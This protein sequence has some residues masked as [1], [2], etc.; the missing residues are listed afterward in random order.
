MTEAI[1]SKA[2]L[3]RLSDSDLT[4]LVGP[5][6]V[7]HLKNKTRG[8]SNGYKGLRFEH[9]FGAHRLA[10]LARKFLEGGTDALVEWQADEFVDDLLVRRDEARSFKGYQLKNAAAVSWTAGK[11][12]IA[13][14]FSIQH[15]TCGAEGYT[16]IRL[17]LVCSSQDQNRAL[18]TVPDGI[19][20]FAR[21]IYFP[22]ASPHQLMPVFRAHEW[23]RNDFAYLSRVEHPGIVQVNEVAGILM[24]AWDLLAPSARVSEVVQQ[25]RQM[26]P[27]L[28]RSSRPDAEASAQ[29][30]PAFRAT[31]ES[32]PDFTY[33]IVRGFL[34]WSAFGG[35]TSGVLS[36]DCFNPKFAGWQQ[37]IA[38]AKPVTFQEVEGV[39]I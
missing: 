12:P 26:S 33:G 35:S 39:F 29:L 30:T 3:A 27:T 24:G 31:I 34:T 16:D 18:E 11:R 22:E 9:F 1:H 38:D 36:I 15:K 13:H 4:A 14:D 23:L 10:R 6:E 5:E 37:H 20:S 28:I 17:R 32:W 2:V 21:A 7:S 19:A 8:G 25:A